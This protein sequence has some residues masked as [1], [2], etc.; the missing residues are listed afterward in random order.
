MEIAVLDAPDGNV[1]VRGSYVGGPAYE[2]VVAADSHV[3]FRVVND[4]Q[5]VWAGPSAEAFRQVATA[6]N[7]YRVEVGRLLTD[8]LKVE[9]AAQLRLELAELGALPPDLPRDPE[10]FWSLLLFEAESGLS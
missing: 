4:R 5:T 8:E 3:D 1:I 2:F 10:P 9:R 7:R 6:W